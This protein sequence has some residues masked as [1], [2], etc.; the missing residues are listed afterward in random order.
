MQ[1]L[2]FF[3]KKINKKNLKKNVQT[4]IC[5]KYTPVA[6]SKEKKRI[7]IFFIDFFYPPQYLHYLNYHHL[8]LVL[9]SLDSF[10][11][12]SVLLLLLI[13]SEFPEICLN[14]SLLL[15]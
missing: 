2:I 8:F 7:C 9:S 13:P 14:L 6:C 10:F 5:T 1:I 15:L 12:G 3:Q 4:R 11:I